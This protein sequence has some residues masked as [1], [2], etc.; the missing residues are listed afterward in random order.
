M[1]M[2]N[3]EHSTKEPKSRSVTLRGAAGAT[4]TV[5]AE[6]KATGAAC[7]VLHSVPGEGKKRKTTRGATTQHAN[8]DAARAAADKL[9]K[10]ALAK[11]WTRAERPAGFRPK[12]DAFTELPS[13]A[14]ASPGTATGSR[15]QP[16]GRKK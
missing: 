2:P 3:T 4:L 6:R 13:P 11:G 8:M 15:P 7:Y 1:T 16:T 14:T 10:D 9:V 5:V 12:P